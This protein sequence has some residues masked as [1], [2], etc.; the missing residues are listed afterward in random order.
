[1]KRKFPKRKSIGRGRRIK[2]TNK[3]GTF[4]ENMYMGEATGVRGQAEAE[5][6]TN[7]CLLV[8]EKIACLG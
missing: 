7:N 2:I 6:T 5:G 8:P 4:V 3:Q 1:M